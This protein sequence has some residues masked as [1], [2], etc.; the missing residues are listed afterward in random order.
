VIQIHPLAA[1]GEVRPGDD[2]VAALA[3]AL[4]A[5]GLVDV[6]PEDVLV[7]TQKIVSK[8]EGRFADLATVTPGAE[9]LRLAAVTGKDARLVELVLAQS[10]AVVR[11]A[12]HVL[13]TRHRRGYV[14]ANAGIDRSNLG[15]GGDGLV[16][17]L[18]QD[19]DASAHAL[20]EG[21]AARLGR[22][23][24]VVI[25]DSFGRPWRQG[26][27]NVALGASGLPSLVDRRGERD[28]DGRRLEVTQ[29]ALGDMVATAAG[30]ATGEGSEGVPAA[31]VRGVGWAAES[32]PAA[33]LIR[34][35][36]E[37]LFS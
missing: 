1:I 5:A 16:L 31:L 10:A 12:P 17:L 26:V 14:M 22:A 34:P 19:A 29:I 15:P 28:R 21:L 11:A 30:L 33:A 3:M 9:A 25:S 32:S 37:D 27:V 13:I 23:P 6:G 36:E 20:R 24:A 2:L 7:V 18:P 8:A 4:D 35:I